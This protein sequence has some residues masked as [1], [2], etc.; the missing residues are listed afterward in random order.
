MRHA[1]RVFIGAGT[2]RREWFIVPSPEAYSASLKLVVE[3]QPEL[4]VRHR[5]ETNTRGRMTIDVQGPQPLARAELH[6]GSR[7]IGVVGDEN[8]V[9]VASL[10]QAQSPLLEDIGG[11]I[12]RIEGAPVDPD[13]LILAPFWLEGFDAL[14]LIDPSPDVL[15]APQ[16][17]DG[18]LDWVALGGMLVVS[19]GEN[20]GTLRSSPLAPY[21]PPQGGAA[22]RRNYAAFLNTLALEQGEVIERGA[23]AFDGTWLRLSRDGKQ[24]PFLDRR[25]GAGRI[26]L[27]AFDARVALQ[28]ATEHGH[29]GAIGTVLSGR[30][31]PLRDEKFGEFLA[32]TM[33]FG[34][35]A[36]V[37][38]SVQ[39]IMSQG[40]FDRP[41]LVLILLA[42]ALYVLVVG[43]LDWIVL[44]RLGK[45][46]LTTFTFGGAVLLFTA[47]A[48]GAS[49][50]VFA[51]GAVLNRMVLIDL[52]DAG[53]D[54]RQLIR[55]HDLVG[56]YSPRGADKEFE[57]SL[58]AV[59]AGAA[60]PGGASTAEVGDALPVLVSGNDTLD[61]MAYVQVAFRSQR[62][63][64]SVSSGTTGRTIEAE[65][66]DDGDHPRLRIV[67]GLP[68]DLESVHVILPGDDGGV[69]RIGRIPTGGEETA[70]W[71]D[72]SR[73][74]GSNWS[75]GGVLEKQPGPT[76]VMGFLGF[77]SRL[78]TGGLDGK[79]IVPG[80]TQPLSVDRQ[81]L[82]ARTGIARGDVLR[83][84]RALLL[85]RAAECP[86]PL[87]SGIDE[88][89]THVLIRMEIELP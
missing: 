80:M 14:V 33:Q 86:V 6:W 62:V 66:I 1:R 9:L 18:V 77:L 32:S 74:L 56:Y 23:H 78:S 71:L 29:F 15:A 67:N 17:L 41:P 31:A 75:T 4:P 65:W 42:L 54:G 76:E 2:T 22:G 69:Y 45:Q 35:T 8:N 44:K 89:T 11:D 72:A 47:V 43:P 36:D 83:H 70:S 50:L 26:R 81:I 53:R 73:S 79:G 21:L 40:A 37:E 38:E 12:N 57:F 5:G 82:L 13:A 87:S 55:V 52:V 49:F 25:M 58:P 85:A 48:Y 59:V 10:P 30:P 64:R 34:A 3:T 7:V 19:P 88:G 24:V 60:L 20:A 68:V 28:A 84:G 51:T 27:L 16:A 61:P 46:R 39:R 63:V